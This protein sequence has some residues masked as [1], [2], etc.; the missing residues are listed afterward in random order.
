MRIE[1]GYFR[2]E[3][4]GRQR[5]SFKGVSF[6][7][8]MQK[9][10]K[11]SDNKANARDSYSSIKNIHAAG[12]VINRDYKTGLHYMSIEGDEAK[13]VSI[14]FL[15]EE[16]KQA[17]EKLA[18]DFMQY[19]VCGQR[20]TAGLYALLEISGNLKREKEGFT[21]LT[22]NGITYIPYNGDPEK[23]WEADLRAS[24]YR[25]AR[26]YLLSGKDCSDSEAWKNILS[27]LNV[28]R[29]DETGI[30]QFEI[31]EKSEEDAQS[32]TNT[33]IIV[34]PDGSRVLMVTINIG[35]MEST[36]SLK[37]SEPTDLPN[38]NSERSIHEAEISF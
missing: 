11:A 20:E 36:M 7:E 31:H 24:D 28:Y 29:G 23:A 26:K 3:A 34:K 35:G 18:D 17:F 25:A 9:A 10:E 21:F 8:E 1:N 32:K 30:A 38:N 22:P 33:E 19:P 12:L 13:G 5:N 2:Q 4:I 37:I 14:I 16:D 27:H 6:A 15:S